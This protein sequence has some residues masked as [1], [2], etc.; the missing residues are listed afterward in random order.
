MAYVAGSKILDDEYNT[1]VNSSG[2]PYGYNHFAGTG[3]SN[4]GLGQSAISTVSV[5]G[6]V[7]ASQWNALFTG[8]DNVAGHTGDTMTSTA[9]RSAGD[10]IAIK[11]ALVAD[12]ASLAASVAA[13]CTSTT[14]VTT[15]ANLQAPQ[16]SATWYGSFTTEVSVTFA[17]A[18][19][20]RHFFNAGG[21]IRMTP[22]RIG[23][24]GS[25]G[26]SGKD[27]SWDELYTAMG[28][29]SIAAHSSTRSGSGETLQTN[30]LTNGF[31]DLSINA[32]Y[33]TIIQLSDNT[34]PYTANVL[35]ISAKITATTMTVKTTATD[36]A[37]DTVYTSG[38]TSGVD[39]NTNRNGKHQHALTTVDTTAA[40]LANAHAPSSTAT[41][42]N[43]TT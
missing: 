12:L 2:S 13:G 14:S 30:G 36:G 37:G 7:Q 23:N 1:F 3:A 40:N 34:Y 29:L 16:S 32:G 38:N 35:N 17:S 18:D 10:S 31:H 42:S 22:T 43:N 41:V 33:L 25:S 6:T 39:I 28:T 5:G 19:K 26:A 8:M 4:Y 27:G 15:S 9:L 20:M 21:K 24:G 11:S